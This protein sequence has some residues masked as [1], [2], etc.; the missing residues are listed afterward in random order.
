MPRVAGTVQ[1]KVARGLVA[2]PRGRSAMVFYA[3]APDLRRLVADRAAALVA[4]ADAAGLGPLR[5]RWREGDPSRD[6]A[7]IFALF[8][9]RFGAVPIL[10]RRT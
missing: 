9:E 4:A 2:Y 6:G 5:L 3:S 10:N 8:V 7:E 1:V